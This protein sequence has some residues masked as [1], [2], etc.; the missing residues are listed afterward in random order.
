MLIK[1][2]NEK[3]GLTL[4]ELLVTIS[5]LG[6]V[7]GI[8]SSIFLGNN[9]I[10]KKGVDQYDVQ[11]NARIAMTDITNSVR[12]ATLLEILPDTAAIPEAS[13]LADN[14]GY[15]YYD[16]SSGDII[17]R[18]KSSNMSYTIGRAEG[19]GVTFTSSPNDYTI[20]VSIKGTDD[21][22]KFEVS[23]N[24]LCLNIR[25]Y[26]ASIKG[27]RT[28]SIVHYKKDIAVP[29]VTETPTETPSEP[30]IVTPTGS[31][32]TENKIMLNITYTLF[33]DTVSRTVNPYNIIQTIYEIKDVKS[34]TPNSGK[35]SKLTTEAVGNNVNVVVDGLK[36]GFNM[37]L[38]VTLKDESIHKFTISY[39]GS[40]WTVDGTKIN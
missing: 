5:L 13:T 21:N 38:E 29:T 12:Y 40:N 32:N 23:S 36:D 6:L 22:K 26:S 20:G 3:K 8:A 9:K 25:L 33:K 16:A 24:I 2:F 30:P 35:H 18:T 34:V 15:I 7:I 17:K 14:E 1:R 4:V 11:S 27:N 37:T 10:F 28:G 31:G 39:S 19:S